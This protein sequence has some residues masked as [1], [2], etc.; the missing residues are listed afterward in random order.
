MKLN[1]DY[2]FV[3]QQNVKSFQKQPTIFLNRKKGTGPKRRK[4]LR[5]TRNVGLG[6]KTPREVNKNNL[7]FALFLKWIFWNGLMFFYQSLNLSTINW[8][9]NKIVQEY[10]KNWMKKDHLFIEAKTMIKIEIWTFEIIHL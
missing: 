6:F 8:I 10:K 9:K 1:I 3:L 4:P 2:F 7:F 5:Y